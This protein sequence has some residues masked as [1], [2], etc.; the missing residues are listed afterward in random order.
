[1]TD[2]TQDTELTPRDR[3]MMRQ[4]YA[5]HLMY[6]GCSRE[7][8]ERMAREAIPEPPA[9]TY[10]EPVPDPTEPKLPDVR[11][12]DGQWG[13]FD[14]MS[15]RWTETAV[16]DERVALLAACVPGLILPKP[17]PTVWRVTYRGG[18]SWYTTDPAGASA[19]HWDTRYP[20][21]APHTVRAYAEVTP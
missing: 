19:A 6:A 18:G 20:R 4:W 8:A 5:K 1:M 9:Y 10:S 2:T 12:S 16:T 15:G 13:F 3:E 17:V 14:G 7:K 21:T 11:R